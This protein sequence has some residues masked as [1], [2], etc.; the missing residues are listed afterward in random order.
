MPELTEDIQKLCI[1]NIQMECSATKTPSQ[2]YILQINC[3]IWKDH[4]FTAVDP[5]VTLGFLVNEHY[6]ISLKE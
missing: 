1:S 2:V 3:L 5:C 4:L 6:R